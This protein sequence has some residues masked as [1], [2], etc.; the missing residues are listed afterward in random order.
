MRMKL[1]GALAALG[2]LLAVPQAWAAVAAGEVALITGRGTAT[3][4][5]TGGIRDLGK[6]A[7]VFPGEI[8]S[9]AVNSYV[10]IKFADGSYI[11]LRPNTRF[12]I[13][14]F[15]L[16][17]ATPPPAAEKPA[18][19]A[20]APA[21]PAAK[22][23]TPAAAAKPAAPAT[24]STA[25]PATQQAAAGPGSRAFFKLLKGGFRAVS[26]LIGKV[27]RND[28]RV[29]TP[30]ATIGIRGTDYLLVL[31]DEKCSTDPVISDSVP[32]GARIEGGLVVG[33]VSGGVA[34]LNN[35]GKEASL[36]ENQYLINLPDGTQIMLP[37][38]PRFLRVDPIPNPVAV[39]PV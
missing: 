9:S 25:A 39:C 5:A 2:L 28:Y 1:S 19:P 20:K 15:E 23:A 36:T 37:F 35:A 11:L 10:N 24:A 16:A 17:A 38:E 6:G 21:A 13:E 34:V 22:P 3:H 8:I 33:V 4:P 18:V 30:V 7:Q 14:E 27:D 12:Q 31:C 26:G 32:E 29:T